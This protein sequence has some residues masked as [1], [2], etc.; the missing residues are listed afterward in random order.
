MNDED[1]HE[2]HLIGVSPLRGYRQVSEEEMKAIGFAEMLAIGIV[3]IIITA[4]LG[5]MMITSGVHMDQPLLP[6]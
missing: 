6:R 5:I 3:V 4:V 1:K 2:K